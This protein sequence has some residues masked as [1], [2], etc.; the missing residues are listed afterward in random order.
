MK[1]VHEL[2]TPAGSGDREVTVAGAGKPLD[3]QKAAKS[4]CKLQYVSVDEA[5]HR[6]QQRCVTGTTMPHGTVPDS[7]I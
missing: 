5:E 3:W 4:G 7:D 1:T 2:Y 6:Q